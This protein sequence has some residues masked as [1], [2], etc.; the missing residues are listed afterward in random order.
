VTGVP[1]PARLVRSGTWWVQ[2]YAYALYWQTRAVL[3]PRGEDAYLSGDGRPVLVVPGIWETW[4]FLRP[5][6][7]R[8]HDEGHPVHVLASLRWNGRPVEVT[9]RDVAA[10]IVAHDLHDVVIVAHS[11]GGLVGKYVM[12]LLDETRRVHRMVAI[13]TPFSGSRYAAWLPLPSLR[14]FSPRDA[15]TLLLARN[16]AVN[17]RIIS[18][19]GEFDPHIPESSELPGAQNIRLVAGGHFRILAHPRT[20]A[21][22]LAT[23]GEGTAT[24]TTAS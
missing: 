2:D 3:F 16:E 10:Y 1:S 21:T 6:I 4:A 13:C 5:L 12:A 19:F 9:A 22:V 20:I 17:E 7:A 23:S 15:T 11:K 18:V 24:P 14:A 8:V